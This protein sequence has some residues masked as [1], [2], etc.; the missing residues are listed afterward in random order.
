ML[1]S[2]LI[3]TIMG[4]CLSAKKAPVALTAIS[5]TAAAAVIY[6]STYR[7]F[8]AEQGLLHLWEVSTTGGAAYL[9]A[10][11]LF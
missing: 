9:V 2:M 3:V 11:M 1:K 7:G 6:T 4:F 10:A 5:T 8:G